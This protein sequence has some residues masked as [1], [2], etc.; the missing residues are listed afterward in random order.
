M[1]EEDMKKLKQAVDYFGHWYDV[2]GEERVA[3]L[4][5]AV[6]ELE[7]TKK[8][9]EENKKLTLKVDRL[10]SACDAY[11]YSQRT[12]QEEIKELKAQIEKMK[13]YGKLLQDIC[14]VMG[15]DPYVVSVGLEN[16]VKVL[17]DSSEEENGLKLVE[18]IENRLLEMKPHEWAEITKWEI[19]EK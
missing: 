12:Y 8:L 16:R 19:K 5:K 1:T 11:N 10:E 6:N 17:W 4:E 7:E 14:T 2:I 15:N 13:K 9:Q 18:D 3:I